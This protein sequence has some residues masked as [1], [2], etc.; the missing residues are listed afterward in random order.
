M[1]E[2]IKSCILVIDD[3]ATDEEDSADSVK[4]Y[5]PV[6][7]T[8]S[9]QAGLLSVNLSSE[10]D[11][12]LLHE[13]TVFEQGILRFP[14]FEDAEYMSGSVTDF[15]IPK[16]LGRSIP[17]YFPGCSV[18]MPVIGNVVVKTV[19]GALNSE[20][21]ASSHFVFECEG[22]P[23]KKK[24]TNAHTASTVTTY[25]P[26]T[27][28][29]GVAL[30][31]GDVVV[32]KVFEKKKNSDKDKSWND[33][34]GIFRGYEKNPIFKY[35]AYEDESLMVIQAPVYKDEDEHELSEVRNFFVSV[36]S[37]AYGLVLPVSFFL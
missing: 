29:A 28:L 24:I 26:A 18:D 17:N 32:L 11:K 23:E 27:S 21:P 1:S 20:S 30:K 4:K 34:L 10:C 2:K 15:Q 25:A 9:L 5:V 6:N 16:E 22:A 13:G 3:E 31:K 12:R 7:V 33:V 8:G 35:G 37:A 36:D 14:S 19:H